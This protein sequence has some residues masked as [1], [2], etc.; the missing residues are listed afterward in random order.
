M[1]HEKDYIGAVTKAREDEDLLALQ[2]MPEGLN[3][4]HNFT[5]REV[6]LKIL[7]C[8]GGFVPRRYGSTGARERHSGCCT[9]EK[10]SFFLRSTAEL[11]KSRQSSLEAT[12]VRLSPSA[13][14]LQFSLRWTQSPKVSTPRRIRQLSDISRITCGSIFSSANRLES[15]ESPTFWRMDSI[16]FQNGGV[17]GNEGAWKLTFLRCIVGTSSESLLMKF[18]VLLITLLLEVN[19][20]LRSTSSQP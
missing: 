6:S 14:C 17:T 12:F 8:G 4:L 18:F 19:A 5:S 9:A 7:N 16:L 15:V 20:A 10:A 2:G 11:E 3:N 13:N 1:L